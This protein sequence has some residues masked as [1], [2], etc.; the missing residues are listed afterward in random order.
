M[1]KNRE[2]NNGSPD[3]SRDARPT[4]GYLAFGIADDVGHA[5]WTGVA[6]AARRRDVNL[7]CF[8]GEKLHDPNGFLAQANVL[9]DLVDPRVADG[10][11]IWAS[12]LSSFVEQQEC[13]AFI[14]SYHPIPTI[15]LGT[16]LPG[17]PSVQIES[18]QG[19]R[20][21]MAHLIQVHGYRRLAFIRG[22]EYHPYAQERYDAYVDALAEH[23]LPID[24]ALITPP[25]D[26]SQAVG[27]EMA[28]LLLD[29]RGLQPGDGLEAI[30]AASDVL[31]LGA[32]EAL[33]AR[34][35]Q[36]PGA[37]ALAGFNSSLEGRAVT[38]PLTSVAAPFYRQGKQALDM[39]LAMLTGAQ[40]PEQVILPARLVVRQSCGCANSAVV[41]ARVKRT[42]ERGGHHPTETIPEIIPAAHRKTLI[43]EM[44]QAAQAGAAKLSPN[45][46][47]QLIDAFVN[48]IEHRAAGGF[49]AT[50]ERTLTQAATADDEAFVWQNAISA[51]HRH[52]LSY[53]VKTETV[54]RVESLL[55]QARVLIS[56]V[57]QRTQ[58]YYEVQASHYNQ[59]LRT[60]G[61]ALIGTFDMAKLR[62]IL[63]KQLP[64]LGIPSCYLS[65]YENPKGP[66]EEARLILAYDHTGQIEQE[67]GNEPFPSSQLVPRGILARKKRYT[68]VVT[69][70]YFEENQLGFA[71]FE[72]GPT[73]G[74]TYGTLRGQ[75]SSALRGALLLQER[76]RAEEALAQAYAR[77]EEQVE[78]RTRE[79]Q[80]EIAERMR[81]EEELQRYREH[82]EE[83][84]EER[85]RELEKA[86]AELVRQERL[87]ALGQLT[88]TVAH[89]IRNPLGTVRTSV[90]SISD[91][92]TRNETER[93]GRALKLAERNIVR[94]DAI[95]TEL[96]DFT[97]DRVLQKSPTQIDAW[98]D[99]LLDELLDQR[100]I[101]ESIAL[102]RELDA[103]V[104]VSVDS[105]HLRR[106]VINILDNAVDAMREKGP[107]EEKNRLTVTTQVSSGRL[108]IRISD[109]GCGI[110]E[111][112]MS[113]VFEPLFSTKSFGIGLGLSI[114][115]SIMEQHDGNVEINS[116]AGEGTTVTLWLPTSNSQ[117]T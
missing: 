63:T 42:E 37:V 28:H 1:K 64:A 96:L 14:K 68:M 85:T 12:A 74:A 84:V 52:V 103:R 22:P 7:I 58:L 21:T 72:M 2:I 66:A 10:L 3:R 87:S 27:H 90:F 6:D 111:E 25:G 45:W 24:S 40:V 105:E 82:L 116:Q 43:S 81:A 13:A 47:T 113:R 115:K 117:K 107:A 49:L 62:D 48:E 17:I 18:Y 109:T 79:L 29:Q 97:R 36:V 78:E 41:Q 98:L 16:A 73:D 75:I 56:E 54:H 106:A 46:A 70:L 71:L 15:S 86:Q 99:R 60:I 110:S 114:V 4:I 108:E 38:P 34:G 30:V 33:Q 93:I 8:V 59:V 67:S 55:Q 57:T 61:Q 69:S 51:L 95:I 91:A 26:W 101:P 32:L 94:C 102:V 77:V 9:Y 88:A 35:I 83:L 23:G 80:Q 65:L 76:Q 19:V 104:E 112:V 39:M 89:E 5:I 44:T 50:L 20:E 11:L 92:I 31:A 100:A 53:P